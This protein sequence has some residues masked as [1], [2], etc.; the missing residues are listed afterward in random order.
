MKHHGRQQEADTLCSTVDGS[1][2]ATRLA[3]QMEALVKS[4]QMLVDLACYFA[5]GLLSYTGKDG[6]AQF[7]G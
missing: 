1:G 3:R 2:Q 5:D 6:V 7:L 4:Q